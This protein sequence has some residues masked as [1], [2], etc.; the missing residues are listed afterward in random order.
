ME[1]DILPTHR[2]R[3][4]TVVDKLE[5]YCQLNGINPKIGTMISK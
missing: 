5:W 4:I 3:G 1:F 2:M